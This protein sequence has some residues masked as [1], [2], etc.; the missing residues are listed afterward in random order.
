MEVTIVYLVI[1]LVP[2]LLFLVPA[3]FFKLR[4]MVRAREG[5][6]VP[7]SAERVS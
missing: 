7:Q 4:A 2:A 3:Q 5:G 1:V 6:D